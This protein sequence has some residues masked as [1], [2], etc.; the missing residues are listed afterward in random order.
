MI[1]LEKENYK[2]VKRIIL[3]FVFV[4]FNNALFG[5]QR[6]MTNGGYS[7]LSPNEKWIVVVN[8]AQSLVYDSNFQPFEEGEN[9]YNPSKRT[10]GNYLILTIWNIRAVPEMRRGYLPFWLEESS[11]EKYFFKVVM[12][13]DFMARE[14]CRIIWSDDSQSVRVEISRRRPHADIYIINYD[15]QKGLSVGMQSLGKEGQAERK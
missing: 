15:F 7:K 12:P 1:S 5:V 2:K 4:I 6:F 14:D 13:M 11:D 8:D 9:Y 10:F 3:I